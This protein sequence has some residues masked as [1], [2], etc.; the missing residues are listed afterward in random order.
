M[1]AHCWHLA[2]NGCGVITCTQCFPL[3]L[4][5]VELST[6][7]TDCDCGKT[8]CVLLPRSPAGSNH[9]LNLSVSRSWSQ[10]IG[11]V[12]SQFSRHFLTGIDLVGVDGQM[13]ILK[14]INWF[15]YEDGNTAPDGIWAGNTA[16]SRDVATIVRFQ[17][18]SH[19][20]LACIWLATCRRKQQL[21]R[22]LIAPWP[23]F[24]LCFDILPRAVFRV[25]P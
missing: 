1:P 4:K 19:Q 24:A 17:G 22:N 18:P 10:P 2:C 15:G 21:Q 3:H 5:L 23:H 14:G 16:T 12:L 6:T 9:L 25:R 7:G 20:I 11:P 8:P 13:L